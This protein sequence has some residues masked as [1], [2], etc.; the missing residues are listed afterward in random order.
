M[1]LDLLAAFSDYNT[2]TIQ[3]APW[4]ELCMANQGQIG[5]GVRG[6]YVTHGALAGAGRRITGA[7]QSHVS[8]AFSRRS[9]RVGR[10]AG[11]TQCGQWRGVQR[12]CLQ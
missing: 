6:I 3:A 2:N 5:Q 7:V 9:G 8:T 11:A 10:R 12:S 4:I 1:L